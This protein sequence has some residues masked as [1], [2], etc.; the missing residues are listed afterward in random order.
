M[1]KELIYNEVKSYLE[2]LNFNTSVNIFKLHGGDLGIIQRGEYIN[3]TFGELKEFIAKEDKKIVE[4][5]NEYG[6]DK[7][8]NY[9]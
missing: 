4:W 5:Y 2:S 6:L 9:Q 7:T 1:N 3:Y 8:I